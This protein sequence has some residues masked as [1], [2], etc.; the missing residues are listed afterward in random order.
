MT[1]R[2]F[3]CDTIV[4]IATPPGEGGIGVVR[5]SGNRAIVIADKIFESRRKLKVH[6]QKSFTAQY[7]HIVSRENSH[8]PEVIDEVLLFLMRTPKSYTCEDVVEISAHGGQAVLQAIVGLAVKN[9]ARL[10]VRGEFTK[11]A[12]LNGRIDLLQAEAVL[13]LIQAKTELGRQWATRELKGILSEKIE[14]FKKELLD[15][16]S[17]LEASIDFPDD[18]PDTQSMPEIA[19]RLEI[20][21]VAIEKLLTGS[22]LGLIV[23]KGLRVAICGRP[24]VGKSSLMNQLSKTNRVIV[25]P[26]P[27]TT[28]DVVEEEIGLGGFPVRILDTA[29][30][31]DSGH[32]I[33]REG[34]ER[35]KKAAAEADLVLYVLDASQPWSDHDEALLLGLVDRP[36]ILV[37]NKCDLSRQL[38]SALLKQKLAQIPQVEISCVT[39]NGVDMLENKILSFITQ[40]KATSSEEAV[41]STIR[42]KE[43]LE[44]ASKNIEDARKGC[45]ARLSPELVALDVRLSLDQLGMLVGEVLTED[46]LEVLFNQFCIG[47]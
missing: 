13:N 1:L 31:H 14:R 4:A 10:A 24:N 17:H 26:H 7:G 40:G 30:I 23:R 5:L 12:F 43:L 35:S 6:E 32:P 29:G 46:I 22:A 16:L 20:L 9:G 3:D 34:I 15:I 18:F 36:K 25:T 39:E 11:R 27:G 28:R 44:K 47:K 2:Q 45:L 42:Q 38:D 37:V 33:E 21:S 8:E 41:V 19:K